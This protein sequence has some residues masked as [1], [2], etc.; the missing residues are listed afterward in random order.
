MFWA[1]YSRNAVAVQGWLC[2]ASFLLVWCLSGFNW[3]FQPLL[4]YY[5]Y[6]LR[7][8]SGVVDPSIHPELSTLTFKLHVLTCSF[9]PAIHNEDYRGLLFESKDI[10]WAFLWNDYYAAN[11]GMKIVLQLASCCSLYIFSSS[12]G[13]NVWCVCGHFKL[14]YQG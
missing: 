5:Y 10:L 14:I 13:W 4:P 8:Y 7:H 1:S 12:K 6:P 3:T 9:P 2:G 11:F